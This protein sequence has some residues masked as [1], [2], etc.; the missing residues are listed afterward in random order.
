MTKHRFSH[1]VS[2]QR[3]QALVSSRLDYANACLFGISN[4]NLSRIQII[5]NTLAQVVIHSPDR[6]PA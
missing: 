3:S 4:K 6:G 1:C 2:K 5:Q